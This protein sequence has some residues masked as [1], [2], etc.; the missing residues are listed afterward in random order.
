MER[1]DQHGKTCSQ[2]TV[3]ENDLGSNYICIVCT[4]AAVLV[5]Y[6]GTHARKL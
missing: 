6:T 1:T 2:S 3:V 5:S 4:A